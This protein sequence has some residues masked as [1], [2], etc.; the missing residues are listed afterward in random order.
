M[1]ASG[2]SIS[3]RGPAAFS[4]ARSEC[5]C[6]AWPVRQPSP[7][8]APAPVPPW[9]DRAPR[10]Y[11]GIFPF[12]PWSQR[13][14]R[15]SVQV[16]QC[17]LW[18]RDPSVGSA[19]THRPPSPLHCASDGQGSKQ[20]RSHLTPCL[21]VEAEGWH[22]QLAR[23]EGEDPQDL[24]RPSRPAAA[25]L[26]CLGGEGPKLQDFGAAITPSGSWR[27]S[28]PRAALSSTR[29]PTCASRASTRASDGPTEGTPA[30]L[31][32]GLSSFDPNR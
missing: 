24:A 17:T 27:P 20:W 10:L 31:R 18:Q 2:W 21:G 19:L 26:P 28:G 8:V 12:S 14:G 11:Q 9:R 15:S 23:G 3:A 13:A 7:L 32:G 5:T 30:P 4:A 1:L 6:T 22:R 16:R 29:S 25:W